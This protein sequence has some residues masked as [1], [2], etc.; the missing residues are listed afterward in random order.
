MLEQEDDKRKWVNL[1]NWFLIFVWLYACHLIR[2][3][4]TSSLYMHMTKESD[5]TGI[6]TSFKE[7]LYNSSIKLIIDRGTNSYLREFEE[8]LKN[9]NQVHLYNL[10]A[11]VQ[12]NI[13]GYPDLTEVFALAYSKIKQHEN[14]ICGLTHRSI[15]IGTLNLKVYLSIS[16]GTID[17]LNCTK[18][19]KFAWFYDTNQN[20]KYFVD[21]GTGLSMY[22]K[23]FVMLFGEYLLIE[24]NEPVVFQELH[25]W[26][27]TGVNYLNEIFNRKISSLAESGIQEYQNHYK[28]MITQRRALNTFLKIS[29]FN[30]SWNMF[31]VVN[32]A[33]AKHTHLAWFTSGSRK[34][35]E[36]FFNAY[37]NEREDFT[38]TMTDLRYV[39]K[40]YAALV[41]LFPIIFVLEVFVDFGSKIYFKIFFG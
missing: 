27:S 39:W 37:R 40:F 41:L 6:P 2:S 25:L 14:Y 34:L 4:Y 17:S 5:P 12:K 15:V 7:L 35:S 22:S 24:N 10:L 33:L 30:Q 31:S 8:K 32:Q 38:G 1:H 36:S 28:Q 18:L 26:F 16:N 23:L 9:P 3:Q 13:D 21:G 19:F 29:R 11:K 20:H